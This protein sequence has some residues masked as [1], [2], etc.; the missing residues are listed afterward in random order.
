[1]RRSIS[2]AKETSSTSAAPRAGSDDHRCPAADNAA[3]IAAARNALPAL[4]ASLHP[5]L[6]PAPPDAVAGPDGFATVRLFA[7]PDAPD[8]REALVNALARDPR[9]R[10][11]G[12]ARARHTLEDVFLAATRPK[13][14]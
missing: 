3:L 7:A 10:L 8:L 14:A 11:R 4:L 1:L 9:F 2:S 5:S 13:A 12:L 6:V